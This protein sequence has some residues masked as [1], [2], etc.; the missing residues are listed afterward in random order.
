MPQI[1]KNLIGNNL[2]FLQAAQKAGLHLGGF[3]TRG[4]VSSSSRG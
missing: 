3:A 4:I 1:K 2:W